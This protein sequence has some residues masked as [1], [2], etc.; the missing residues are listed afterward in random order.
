MTPQVPV[1]PHRVSG[2]PCLVRRSSAGSPTSSVGQSVSFV[3]QSCPTLCNPMDCRTPGFPVHHQLLGLAQIHVHWVGD[4]I[5]PLS[6]PSPPAFSL[7][8]YQGLFKRVSS[9]HRWSKSWGFSLNISLSNEYS[10]LISFRMDRFDLTV[11]GTLKSLLQHHSSKASIL[12]H[13]AFFSPTL[14]SIHDY[15][16]NHSFD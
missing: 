13:S 15:W 2:S 3:T 16:K 9:L 14:T 6:S 7:S 1:G 10:G 12:R 11:Q 5:Q 4:A 8:L